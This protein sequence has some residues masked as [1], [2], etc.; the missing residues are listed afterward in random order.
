MA[1]G[2][3]SVPVGGVYVTSAVANPGSV[4]VEMLAGAVICGSSLSTTVTVNDALA[5]FPAA[6]DAVQSTVVSPSANVEPGSGVHDTSV[7][8]TLS[9]AGGIG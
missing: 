5:V 9:S 3:L 4:F 1:P 7:T 2:A 8:P 6:S